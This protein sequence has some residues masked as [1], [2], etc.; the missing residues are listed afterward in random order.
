M[1]LNL[2]ASPPPY[3]RHS[4]TSKA[5]ADSMRPFIVNTQHQAILDALTAYG[6][7]TDEELQ[8][9]TNLSPNSE[10]PRRV[11]LWRAGKLVQRGQG[12]TRAGRAAARWDVA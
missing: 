12:V 7:L 10:R 4:P 9:A 3:Q 11:E 8:E 5:A 2:L 6:P 1:Q